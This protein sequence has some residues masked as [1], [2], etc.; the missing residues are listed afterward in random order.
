MKMYTI[1]FTKK[2]AR[3]FFG[4]LRASGLNDLWTFG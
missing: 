3:T 4:L 2:P 1:G